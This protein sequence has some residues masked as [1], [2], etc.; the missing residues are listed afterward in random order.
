MDLENLCRQG[1]LHFNLPECRLWASV[2]I[3]GQTE[4]PALN[5]ETVLIE[6]EQ[7]R[8]C[9]TWRG[10]VRCDKKALKVEQIDIHL[11]DLQLA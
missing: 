8:L 9:M 5:L 2:R 10:A 4:T 1:P 6:P 3:A 11:M 7:E